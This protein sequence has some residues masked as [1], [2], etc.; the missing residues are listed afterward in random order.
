MT[1]MKIDR[2]DST[3][4]ERKQ[5][6]IYAFPAIIDEL[7]MALT[8]IIDSQMVST[9]G[10]VYI[11]AVSVTSQPKFFVFVVFS[12]VNICISSL[13]AFYF[14][15]G[16]KERANAVFL[17]A[18]Y[19][20]LLASFVLSIASILA[21]WPIMRLCSGQED[22]MAL[23]VRYFR[24]VMG[25]MVF[26][27]MYLL[28]NAA[29]R[30][31]GKSRIAL[32]SNIIFCITNVIFNYLLIMGKAGFPA[33][34]IDGAALAT[35]IGTAAAFVFD[36]I[37]LLN[38]KLF[39]NIRFIVKNRIKTDKAAVR[40]LVDMWG[41]VL[42]EGIVTKF[43]LIVISAINARMGST[44][45]AAYSVSSQLLSVNAAVG[46]GIQSAG[47]AL[48]GKCNGEGNIDGIK[49]YALR[50]KRCAWVMAVI[51]AIIIVLIAPWYSRLFGSNE[52]FLELAIMTCHFTAVIALVQV[53]K[54]MYT[55]LLQGLKRMKD[56]RRASLVALVLYQP[57][58]SAVL[59][60]GL[61]WGILG[62]NIA[63]FTS[64][65]IW[66]IVSRHYYKKAELKL[67][68]Q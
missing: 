12:S 20:V 66:L 41:N 14:G 40:E 34:G 23:S 27:H 7:F 17:T 62:A 60:L 16:K 19:G 56:T 61:K 22:T 2:S 37:I 30:G 29:L 49:S 35:V 3:Q 54:F 26:N 45:M 25:G 18:L 9:L 39:V 46:R 5:I 8:G 11:A 57:I 13:V 63:A 38:E 52:V 32:F 4:Y 10:T 15:K 51:F 1:L 33:M 64:Q 47:V 58:V 65:V 28:I 67:Y 43:G 6:I 59:V 55:G 24:I 44:G 31:F 48:V 42:S 21:A 50:L 68:E 36:A 53:P